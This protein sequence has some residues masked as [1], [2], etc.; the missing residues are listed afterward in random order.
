MQKNLQ[1]EN[2]NQSAYSSIYIANIIKNIENILNHRST[3]NYLINDHQHEQDLLL[4]YG[5]P[6]LGHFNPKSP[7]DRQQLANLIKEALTKYE[8]RLQEVNVHLLPYDDEKQLNLQFTIEAKVEINQELL[9]LYF[10]FDPLKQKI[11]SKD[12][13]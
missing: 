9:L 12:E 4:S 8:Y 1:T 5:I 2:I 11:S 7:R 13:L 3:I 10:E 6:D